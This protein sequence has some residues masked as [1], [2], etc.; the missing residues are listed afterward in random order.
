MTKSISNLH[1]PQSAVLALQNGVNVK[2]VRKQL[3]ERGIHVFKS[4]PN[5]TP[6]ALFL[7]LDK[8]DVKDPWVKPVHDI[9]RQQLISVLT[10]E[11]VTL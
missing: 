11:I 1:V 6:K 2:T 3:T 10:E 8:D 9:N 4:Q 5:G 7:S